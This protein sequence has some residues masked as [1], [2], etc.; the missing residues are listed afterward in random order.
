MAIYTL[1][2]I[3]P[4]MVGR[5]HETLEL[6]LDAWLIPSIIFDAIH[7]S[8]YRAFPEVQ[9][10]EHLHSYGRNNKYPNPTERLQRFG[11]LRTSG[12]FPAFRIADGFQT[13][14]STPKDHRLTDGYIQRFVPSVDFPGKC[15]IPS[16][17]KFPMI[18]AEKINTSKSS[19]QWMSKHSI[20]KWLN[21]KQLSES[22][23]KSSE[24]FFVHEQGFIHPNLSSGKALAIKFH[25]RFHD[26][27]SLI[28]EAS[29]PMKTGTDGLDYL[30]KNSGQKITVGG[31]D[32]QFIITK[33]L[34]RSLSELLPVGPT[35]EGNRVKWLLLT[36]AIFIKLHR[37]NDRQ[38]FEHPG[39]WLPSWI[40]P[41][42]GQVMLKKEVPVRTPAMTRAQ[43]RSKIK[44]IEKI[45]CRLVA[46]CVGVPVIITGWSNR[47]HL[48]IYEAE[49]KPGFKKEYYAVPAGSI[50]YFEGPDA[51]ILAT[52]LSWH[53]SEYSNVSE[54]KNR[55]SGILGE[56]GFGIGVCGPW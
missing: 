37:S 6:F 2:P 7:A 49:K 48:T 28:T 17:L 9:L 35:I 3:T 29:M 42:T 41:Q 26:Y 32:S 45:D 38:V 51:P 16:P 21:N 53:G 30:V 22:D 24:D 36:P 4:L 1:K 10:W 50:Y 27:V 40:D 55:R 12:L 43:W 19:I 5:R 20:E 11:S 33:D 13:F 54:I 31:Y 34:S 46:A 52:V 56:K 44:S 15:N 39:G 23:F 8:L 47:R 25:V 18:T 14:F